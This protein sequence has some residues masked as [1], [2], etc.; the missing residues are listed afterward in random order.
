MMTADNYGN[1]FHVAVYDLD[2]TKIYQFALVME[3]LGAEVVLT[4]GKLFSSS[5]NN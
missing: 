5:I 2:S 1:N 3:Y 4:K